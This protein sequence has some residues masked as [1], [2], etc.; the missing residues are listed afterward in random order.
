MILSEKIQLYAVT[1]LKGAGYTISITVLTFC[2][3]IV[4]GLVFG[5]I[6]AYGD[7]RGGAPKKFY[8]RVGNLCDSAASAVVDQYFC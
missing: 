8:N 5:A 1:L 2:F 3:A 7:R 4:I 6:K